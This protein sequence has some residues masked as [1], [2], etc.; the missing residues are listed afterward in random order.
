MS[1]GDQLTERQLK[2]ATWWVE[3]RE[4]VRKVALGVFFGVD[5]LLI[6]FGVYG[7]LDYFVISSGQDAALRA[8]MAE[9]VVQHEVAVRQA[10]VALIPVS[11]DAFTASGGKYDFLASIA[12]PNLNWY[13]TLSYRFVGRSGATPEQDSFILPQEEKYLTTLGVELAAPPGRPELEITRLDW[14]RVDRHVIRDLK[15]WTRERR[16][17]I[18]SDVKH[19]SALAIDRKLGRTTFK[20]ENRTAYGYWHAGFFVVPLRGKSPVGASYVTL[21]NFD[22]GERREVS[23]NWFDEVPQ[24]SDV[25]VQPDINLFDPAVYMPPR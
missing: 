9:T 1:E 3:H 23:I 19:E 18:V 21:D 15:T 2:L 4:Q 13:A 11:V 17:F 14:H 8:R 6:I 24:A 12:N 10:P 22:A 20:V 5:A 25:A 16:N 7:L